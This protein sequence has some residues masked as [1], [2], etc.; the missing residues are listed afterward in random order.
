MTIWRMRITCWKTK[1][2]NTLSDYI[3]FIAFHGKNYCMNAAQHHV[4]RTYMVSI[5]KFIFRH[6][7][8]TTEN[9]VRFH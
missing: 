5:F 1:A 7:V 8:H 6:S 2:T 9:T 3:I 4:I